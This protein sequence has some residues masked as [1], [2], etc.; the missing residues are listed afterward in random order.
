MAELWNSILDLR[1]EGLLNYQIAGKLHKTDLMISSSVTRMRQAGLQVPDS[2]YDRA[3]WMNKWY[4]LQ[5]ARKAFR[6]M[7]LGK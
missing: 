1:E 2:T 4:E 7:E 3:G 5:M 6:R